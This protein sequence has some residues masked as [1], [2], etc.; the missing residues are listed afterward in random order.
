MS[1]GPV[2]VL[3]QALSVVGQVV[4]EGQH[5]DADTH[6]KPLGVVCLAL[7]VRLRYRSYLHPDEG[8]ALLA[9]CGTL[10]GAGCFGT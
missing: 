2:P 8:H 3:D 6:F 5:S 7:F 4:A 1:R 9:A 10:N